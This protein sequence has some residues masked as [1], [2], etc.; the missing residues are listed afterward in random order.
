VK[1]QSVVEEGRRRAFHELFLGFSF[2]LL[3]NWCACSSE[4]G[5]R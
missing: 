2:H 1:A 4:D 5:E 3:F